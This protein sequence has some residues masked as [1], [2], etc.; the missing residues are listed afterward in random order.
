MPDGIYR[1]LLRIPE[2]LREKL[3]QSAAEAGRSFNAEV[4]HRLEQSFEAEHARRVP[5]P[6]RPTTPTQGRNMSGSTPPRRGPRWAVVGVLVAALLALAA[7]SALGIVGEDAEDAG[8]K[9]QTPSEFGKAPF[10]EAGSEAELLA[11]NDFFMSRRTAG[12]VPLDNQQAGAMRAEA[13]RAAARI[14]KEGGAGSGPSTFDAAWAGIGPNPIVQGLRSPGSQRYGAMSG[15]IG[16]LAIRKDGTRILAGAQGGIWIWDAATGTWTAKTDSLPSL[17]MGA[18]AVAPSN[19]SIV[20]AGTGEGAFSGDSYFGNGILKSS[21]GGATWSQVSGDYFR[22]VSISRLVVDPTNASHLY[23]AVIRGRG[24]ARR[25]SPPIH[26]QWGI[27]ESKDGAATWTLI[28]PVSGDVL[29]ATDLEIDPLNASTLYASFLGDA[30]YK[31]TNGGASW[32]PIMNGIPG[33]SAQHAGN[34]TRFSIGISHPEG[35]SAVL[36]AGFDWEDAGGYHPSRI[37]KSTDGG[38]SWTKTSD[39]AAT[40]PDNVEDYCG[41]QCTYDNVVEVDPNNTNVVYA[42]GMFNYGNGTGGIYRSDDGGTTWLDLGWDQHPDFHAF[43]FDPNNSNRIMM[44]NDGGAWWSDNRGG[45]LNGTSDPLNAVNWQSL[46]TV[47]NPT[48]RAVVGNRAGLQIGQFTSIA[49]IP[50]VPGRYWGGTQDNGTMKKSGLNDGW[51]DLANGDGGQVLVDPTADATCQTGI[52][53]LP[54]VPGPSCFVYGTYFGISPYRFT[55]GGSFFFNNQTNIRGGLNTSERATFY[56]PIAMNKEQTNQLFLGTYRL[57]RTDN[58]RTPA[59]TDVLWK[60]I[61]PD[62][63]LGCAGTA[64]NG[65]RSCTLSAIGVGGGDGVYTGAE[66]GSVFVSTNAKSAAAPAWTRI[67]STKLPERPITSIAVDRSN[68]RIAY[69]GY[70]GFNAAT[71]ARPGH[72]WRT[73]DGGQT[74][75]DI[76]G[77]LPDSPV[78]SVILDPSYPNTLY[79]GTDVGAFVTYNGGGEWFKLGSGFPTVA[80]WQLDLDPGQTKRVLVAGTHGRGVFRLEDGSQ[81]VPALIVSKVDAGL[82]VGP[83]SEVTYTVNLKNIGNADAT[84]VTLADPVPAN[85]TYVAGSASNGGSLVNGKVTWTNL[86]VP[87]SATGV[88]GAV[89]LT[90]KVSIADALKKKVASITN[91]GI[92]VTSAQNVGTTGSPF[93]TPI[94]APYAVS[95][96]P[97]TQTDGGRGPVD[98]DYHVTLKNN[99]FNAD[100]YTMSSTGSVAG[101]NVSFLDTACSA[102]QPVTPSVAPGGTTDVCVRVHIDSG[103]GA[104]NIANVIATSVGNPAVSASVQVKT[105][106]VAVDT[107]LVDNDNNAPDVQGIYKTALTTAGVQFTTWDLLADG[108]LSETFILGFKNVVWFSGNSWPEPVVPYEPQLTAFLDAGGNLFMSGQDILDQDGGTTDFVHNYLHIDWDGTEAQNDKPTANVKGVTGN[109][110]SN[111]IG[112]VP[113]DHTVLGANFEDRITP[114]APATT[115]F[116]DDSDAANALSFAGDYKVVFLA[117]PLESYGTA[118]QKADLI[119]RT[120]TFFGP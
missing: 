47:I 81:A 73:R 95:A 90:F 50:T 3:S 29:G 45:R 97:A 23:V 8:K 72:V 49:T 80:I 84:N 54:T 100:T 108:S 118:Q 104:T 1:Y 11:R 21:D 9:P 107:L 87:K 57:W 78:N 91:D 2:Q 69:F 64:P 76:S 63:T 34:L 10:T 26:S 12:S 61:S 59:P 24:G 42:G 28:K 93:T 48:T 5:F 113:L 83:T 16:A 115:A 6:R 51:S 114:I 111:G 117:F 19:D 44:G 32:S 33:T 96:S 60:P 25:T 39:G 70:A 30:M 53:Q 37:W 13:A 41:Q 77:N 74:F 62:L 52:P 58:A 4:R 56:I 86:T 22:G 14:R 66:D 94:A 17:A 55:E 103:A 40:G 20:Y 92:T 102:A 105:I 71:P 112:T 98:V 99:G 27:W 36:Y 65:A 120:M 15:R 85:T 119:T 7:G 82:P 75:D 46:N 67:G 35:Q 79:V 88:P 68:Y 110:V 38:A 31:S 116:T 109:P 101:F 18:L 89:Q 106:G 43:A